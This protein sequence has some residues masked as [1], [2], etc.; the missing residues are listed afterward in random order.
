MPESTDTNEKIT[1]YRGVSENHAKFKDALKGIVRPRGGDRTRSQ[2]N[3]GDTRSIYTSWSTER[4]VAE[5]RALE[6]AKRGVVLE[7]KFKISELETSPDFSAESEKLVVGDVSDAKVF[8]ITEPETKPV[9]DSES[10]KHK[11]GGKF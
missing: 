6:N 10:Q 1:L 2:H 9:F 11:D 5:D 8:I 4:W 3:M 7:K